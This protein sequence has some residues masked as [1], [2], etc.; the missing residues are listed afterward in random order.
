MRSLRSCWYRYA[1]LNVLSTKYLLLFAILFVVYNEIGEKDSKSTG[2]LAKVSKHRHHHSLSKLEKK[3]L[4][5]SKKLKKEQK[6]FEEIE[7]QVEGKNTHR[8]GKN[9][10]SFRLVVHKNV[11]FRN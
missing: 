2:K 10:R 7:S 1:N 3:K 5:K 6:R 4:K 9:L 11:S 8:L